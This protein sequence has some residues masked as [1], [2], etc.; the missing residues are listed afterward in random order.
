M[1]ALMPQQPSWIDR[2][3]ERKLKEIASNPKCKRKRRRAAKQLLR[4]KRIWDSIVCW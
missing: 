2:L 4:L 1:N 3:I